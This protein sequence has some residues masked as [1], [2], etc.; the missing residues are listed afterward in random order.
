MTFDPSAHL[1]KLP[2]RKKGPNGQ[3]ITTE[4]DYLPVAA[5]VAWFRETC[6]QGSIEAEL[7]TLDWEKGLAIFRATVRDGKGGTATAYAHEVRS[8]FPDFLEKANTRSVGRALALMGY[9]TMMAADDLDEGD[10]PAE[11]PVTTLP[12]DNI[13][14]VYSDPHIH[15]MDVAGGHASEPHP[16][17]EEITT[18]VQSA[19]AA[20]VSNDD[21]AHDMRRLLNVPDSQKVTKKWLRETMTMDQYNQARKVYGDR[22][23]AIL[24]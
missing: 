6:Q 20:N 15:S 10:H 18:L 14:T 5:R 13:T 21:F 7:V 11:A 16:S 4:A 24:A 12:R 1:M 2:Q 8:A 9:G 17:A 19:Q 3:W 23:A 22:L